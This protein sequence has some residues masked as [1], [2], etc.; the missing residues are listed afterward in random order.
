MDKAKRK[1]AK[2]TFALCPFLPRWSETWVWCLRCRRTQEWLWWAQW[3]RVAPTWKTAVQ[4]EGHRKSTREAKVEREPKIAWK[5]S[6]WEF[7]IWHVRTSWHDQSW[8]SNGIFWGHASMLWSIY[9]RRV[10]PLE[11]DP[12]G[13]VRSFCAMRGHIHSLWVG[14][15]YWKASEI[16]LPVLPSWWRGGL[17]PCRLQH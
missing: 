5:K 2:L 9:H 13:C 1:S 4:A 17:P 8:L 16:K 11:S 12:K 10:G 3:R 7:P 14:D 6:S 15:T